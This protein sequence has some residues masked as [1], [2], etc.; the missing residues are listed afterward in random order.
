MP[1][2]ARVLGSCKDALG[3]YLYDSYPNFMGQK[4][5]KGIKNGTCWG[6]AARTSNLVVWMYSCSVALAQ[7]RHATLCTGGLC[8]VWVGPVTF[9]SMWALT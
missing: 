2:R 7:I 9:R 8:W 4:V 1:P 5:E 6:L 3:K